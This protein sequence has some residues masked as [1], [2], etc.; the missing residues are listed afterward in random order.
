MLRSVPVLF[1][2]LS[3]VRAPHGTAATAESQTTEVRPAVSIQAQAFPLSA[4][5]LL[6]GPFRQAME[7]DKAFL[8]RL[9]PDRLLAGF[10]MQAGLSKKA[11]P[12]GSREWEAIEP[13]SRYTMAGHSLG[14]Y[15][16]RPGDD[17]RRHGRH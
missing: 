14:H 12:Y 10:R 1:L 13:N 2:F 5:K 6:D 15:S 16:Q 11:E 17:G 9:S 8:L 7:V 3:A 4:V